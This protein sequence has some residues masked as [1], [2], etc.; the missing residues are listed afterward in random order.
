MIAH[1]SVTSVPKLPQ[2]SGKYRWTIVDRIP[3][4]SSDLS[5]TEV[6]G[7]ACIYDVLASK[8]RIRGQGAD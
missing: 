7:T 1:L 8:A 2:F 6:D 4:R 3:K 5:G